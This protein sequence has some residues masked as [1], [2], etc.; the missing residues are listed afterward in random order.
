MTRKSST[1][2]L[3]STRNSTLASS[4]SSVHVMRH[5]RVPR[6]SLPSYANPPQSL[7]VLPHPIIPPTSSVSTS[8]GNC[9]GRRGGGRGNRR[10]KRPTCSGNSSS[11]SLFGLN[12][13]AVDRVI[14]S[15]VGDKSKKGGGIRR[16]EN[17][18]TRAR[19]SPPYV[20]PSYIIPSTSRRSLTPRRSRNHMGAKQGD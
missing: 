14:P 9:N 8:Q 20:I 7:R 17:G 4:P 10:S 16:G 19:S 15:M 5:E 6:S 1:I 18:D 2:T 13:R 11:S 3:R 12:P